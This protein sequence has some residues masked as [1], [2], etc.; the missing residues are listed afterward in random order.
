M[1]KRIS[2]VMPGDPSLGQF[3]LIYGSYFDSH[4]YQ[5]LKIKLVVELEKTIYY[6]LRMGGL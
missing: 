6:T 4:Y 2:K 1:V 3:G 5:S